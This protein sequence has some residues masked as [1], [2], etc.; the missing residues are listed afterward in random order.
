MIAENLLARLGEHGFTLR[1]QGEAMALDNPDPKA[2]LPAGMMGELKKQKP[3]LVALC[4]CSECGR[5]TTNLEDLRKLAED[6]NGFCDS[7]SCPYRPNR[8]Y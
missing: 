4:L 5:V 8:R 7:G 6:F 3:R 2:K 1:I